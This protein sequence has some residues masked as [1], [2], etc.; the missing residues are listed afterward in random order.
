MTSV[1]LPFRLFNRR[2]QKQ[3]LVQSVSQG[4]SC[5]NIAFQ[6][7]NYGSSQGNTSGLSGHV[8][9]YG[10]ADSNYSVQVG[11]ARAG[12]EI[13]NGQ[14]TSLQG[15]GFSS[16]LHLSEI[17]CGTFSQDGS[18]RYFKWDTAQGC[19]VEVELSTPLLAR[20]ARS[21]DAFL[22]SWRLG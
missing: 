20:L 11:N 10:Q 8:S 2:S 5:G 17:R 21:L 12:V 15:D 18:P 4:Q 19:M 9:S 22:R 16:P 14:G 7:G 1:R 3:R 13:Q 6:H